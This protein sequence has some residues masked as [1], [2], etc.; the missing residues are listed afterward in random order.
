MLRWLIGGGREP[1]GLAEVRRGRVGSL[2]GG[3]SPFSPPGG[4]SGVCCAALRCAG[5]LWGGAARSVRAA[6]WRCEPCA[7]GASG[8]NARDGVDMADVWAGSALCWVWG[9]QWCHCPGPKNAEA[10]LRLTRVSS[11][12]A[13]ILPLNAFVTQ[14]GMRKSF[15]FSCCAWASRDSVLFCFWCQ[16]LPQR[17]CRWPVS[18]VQLTVFSRFVCRAAVSNSRADM[19]WAAPLLFVPLQGLNS[20]CFLGMLYLNKAECGGAL[21]FC[22]SWLSQGWSMGL[23]SH[24]G[25]RYSIHSTCCMMVGILPQWETEK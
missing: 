1:Q 13:G 5:S 8:G 10:S 17:Q 6:G 16:C 25:R 15:F 22:L 4:G 21:P 24:C 23:F 12:V 18:S 2:A 3:T 7:G 9:R 11:A 20:S 19:G 14:T